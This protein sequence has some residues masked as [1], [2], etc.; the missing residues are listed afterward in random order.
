[1]WVARKDGLS[2]ST[3]EFGVIVVVIIL[4]IIPLNEGARIIWIFIVHRDHANPSGGVVHHVDISGF[5]G[6]R[7]PETSSVEGVAVG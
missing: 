1:M 5:T 4:V 6:D 2:R 7:P 3:P